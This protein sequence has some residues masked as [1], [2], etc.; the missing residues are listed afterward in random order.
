MKNLDPNWNGYAFRIRIRIHKIKNREKNRLTD[1]SPLPYYELLF[2]VPYFFSQK[3]AFSLTY[4]FHMES[5]FIHCH[6]YT[7][8]VKSYSTFMFGSWLAGLLI[9]ASL[10]PDQNHDESDPQHWCCV[11]FLKIGT[12]PIFCLLLF[13]WHPSTACVNYIPVLKKVQILK[14]FIKCYSCLTLNTFIIYMSGKNSN[15]VKEIDNI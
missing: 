14:Q 8:V 1:N 2:H 4:L 6:V 12:W 7:C 3:N 15:N 10:V 9:W 13:V 5:L 11:P